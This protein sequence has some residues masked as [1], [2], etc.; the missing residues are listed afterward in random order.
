MLSYGQK[1]SL[2]FYKNYKDKLDWSFISQY[3]KN[4]FRFFKDV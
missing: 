1:F 2:N 3:K 4:G